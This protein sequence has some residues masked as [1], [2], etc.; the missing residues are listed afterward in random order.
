[1]LSSLAA[2]LLSF[3]AEIA[4]FNS[5]KFFWVLFFSL[6][7][8]IYDPF[9][10]NCFLWWCCHLTLSCFL[11]SLF[12]LAFFTTGCMCPSS[13]FFDQLPC[14]SLAFYQTIVCL[15][16]ALNHFLILQ[17]M[18]SHSTTS[19]PL[20]FLLDHSHLINLALLKYKLPL[21]LFAWSWHHK[22]T[23]NYLPK[24]T[25]QILLTTL[26]MTRFNNPL[27]S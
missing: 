7:Q 12:F 6:C 10:I 8:L 1:M 9:S 18:A 26:H 14:H 25:F 5:S 11:S 19:P 24:L 17:T 23:P 21:S 15:S 13:S 27:H 3:T 4:S 22:A 16:I 20:L 2:A